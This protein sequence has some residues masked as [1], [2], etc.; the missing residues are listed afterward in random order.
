MTI[1]GSFEVKLLIDKK[2]SKKNSAREIALKVIHDVNE[3]GSY[4][5][6]ALDKALSFS[7]LSMRERRRVSEI[8]NGTIRM[9]KRLD[10][11][12]DLF[13]KQGIRKQHPWV[14]NILRMSL[15]QMICMAKVPDYACVNEAVELTR[16]KTRQPALSRVVNGVLRSISRSRDTITWPEDEL[17]YLS[18]YYSHPSWIVELLTDLYGLPACKSILEYNNTPAPLVLRSNSL[19]GTRDNLLRSLWAEGV[20][21]SAS[22]RTP[23]GIY[24]EELNHPIAGLSAYQRGYFYV[25]NDASM[26]AAAILDP[27]PGQIVYD[28]CAGVGGKTTHLAEYMQNKGQIWAYDIYPQKV[29]LL[30]HNCRRMGINIVQARVRSVF[31]QGAEGPLADCVL[32]DAPC[33]GLGVLNRRPD[34]RFRK[35][36]RDTKELGAIQAQMLEKAVDLLAPGGLLLYATCT[37]H[38]EENEQQV[39]AVLRNRSLVLEGFEKRLSFWGLDHG[40]KEQASRGMLAIIPGKYNSDGMFYALMRRTE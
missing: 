32:L 16:M 39:S 2:V 17:E 22:A 20:K 34:S 1:S 35:T 26:L 5:N 30:Q 9:T 31:D 19:Y 10:W 23:W 3:K 33:S 4:A 14:R 11:V 28:L 21:C 24:V 8:V 40:D 6:L 15:Y 29:E 37:I 36:L 27:G 12:L 25:Q 18:V 7:S 38:P 13:L